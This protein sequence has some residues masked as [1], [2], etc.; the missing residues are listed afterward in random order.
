MSTQLVSDAMTMALWR[1]R[2]NTAALLHHSDQGTQPGLN[3]SSQ[4]GFSLLSVTLS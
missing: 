2:P 1:R 3:R 4:H